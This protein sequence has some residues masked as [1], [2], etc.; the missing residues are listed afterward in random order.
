MGYWW[1]GNRFQG[2]VEV[3]KMDPEV[4]RRLKK[5]E[6]KKV[7]DKDVKEKLII[8]RKTKDK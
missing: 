6:Q 4:Q 7:Y 1:K 8:D 5:N 2:N 3:E